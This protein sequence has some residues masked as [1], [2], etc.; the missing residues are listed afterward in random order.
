MSDPF[1]T[2][3][4]GAFDLS[5]FED[6][7]LPA[8][9]MV[10]LLL[11]SPIFAECCKH[12]NAFRLLGIGMAVWCVAAICSGLSPNFPLLLIARAFV[13]VGEASFVALAAPFIGEA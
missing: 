10:G 7:M 2:W 5:Y 3:L 6:G 8:L 11:S 9:F 13:G 1:P 12:Y 4:Q